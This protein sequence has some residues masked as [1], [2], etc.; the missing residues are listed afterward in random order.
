MT[1]PVPCARGLAMDGRANAIIAALQLE[2]TA[3]RK[4]LDCP[5]CY[6]LLNEPTSTPCGHTFCRNCLARV[7]DTDTASGCPL[8]RSSLHGSIGFYA[9]CH[10]LQHI[11]KALFP[12]ENAQ[13]C[14][15]SAAESHATHVDSEEHLALLAPVP[16][17]LPYQHRTI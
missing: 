15:D 4:L 12:E 14:G 9:P 16:L 3:T 6:K 7:L 11:V 2:C 1:L 10:A 17:V 5:I 8:C 13:C